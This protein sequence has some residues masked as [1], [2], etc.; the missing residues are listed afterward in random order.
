MTPTRLVVMSYDIPDDTRRQRLHDL[1]RQYGR[2]VQYSVFEARLTA[3]EVSD[4]VR[5]AARMLEPTTDQLV[6]YPIS[7][8]SE[9]QIAVVGIERDALVDERYFIV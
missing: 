1:L 2:R 5:R 6:V 3:D 7:P 8:R 9:A 4:L